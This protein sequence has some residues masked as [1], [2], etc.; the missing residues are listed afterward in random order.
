[1]EKLHI[2]H[3]MES[4]LSRW[5]LVIV[6]L[7][8][9]NFVGSFL[10][11]LKTSVTQWLLY[12][13]FI[14]TNLVLN[15]LVKYALWSYPIVKSDLYRAETELQSMWVTLR[16]IVGIRAKRSYIMGLIHMQVF[17][18]KCFLHTLWCL[19]PLYQARLSSLCKCAQRYRQTILQLCL[20]L[21]HTGA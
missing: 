12:H 15:I 2:L 19:K 21:G 6:E 5:A 9:L 13:S 18:L 14:F 20:R 11:D 10:G 4:T 1:M 3:P 17:W 16:D 7:Q 8:S